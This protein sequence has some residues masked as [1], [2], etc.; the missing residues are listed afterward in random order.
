[1]K[2]IKKALSTLALIARVIIYLRID[3]PRRGY[4]N[5]ET[6]RATN[7]KESQCSRRSWEFRYLQDA[8]RFGNASRFL[9]EGDCSPS[10]G[11]AAGSLPFPPFD[12]TAGPPR[13]RA[14][15]PDL[16]TKGRRARR[17]P[18]A[19]YRVPTFKMASYRPT[20]VPFRPG[21]E[22]R[23]SFLSRAH[24]EGPSALALRAPFPSAIAW[25]STAAPL[26]GSARAFIPTPCASPRS[27][28]RPLSFPPPSLSLSLS[29]IRDETRP[30]RANGKSDRVLRSIS[31]NFRS[32]Q[33]QFP[34]PETESLRMARSNPRIDYKIDTLQGDFT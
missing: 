23:G 7:D 17:S 22:L 13:R 26:G 30:I 27:F 12:L 16:A 28:F 33:S 24:R 32:S 8:F 19:E 4:R 29:R 31:R 14:S 21:R 9:A 6:P 3:D 25:L 18:R 15:F 5:R 2:R 20:R 10:F 1:M 11:A 34:N